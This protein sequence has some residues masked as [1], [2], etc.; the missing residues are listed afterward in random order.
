[1]IGVIIVENCV[2][3]A[4]IMSE[5]NVYRVMRA[6][7]VA[8]VSAFVLTV[9]VHAGGTSGKREMRGVWVASVWGIDWPSCQGADQSVRA[10]QQREM[11]QILDRCKRLNLTTVCFQV[12]VWLM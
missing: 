7:C 10:K 4:L 12:R 3:F 2:N 6:W 9:S 1:M 8:I 11:S 5:K